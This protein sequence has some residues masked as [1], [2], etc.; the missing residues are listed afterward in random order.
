MEVLPVLNAIGWS[1]EVRFNEAEDWVE[2]RGWEARF[3]I[4][5][6]TGEILA[7]LIDNWWELF[8]EPEDWKAR[9]LQPVVWKKIVGRDIRRTPI[10][11]DRRG[12]ISP[13]AAPSTHT[14]GLSGVGLGPNMRP[15]N[16]TIY[17][18]HETGVVMSRWTKQ[19][20]WTVSFD[21]LIPMTMPDGMDHG[22]FL[23]SVH[24]AGLQL[25]VG[26]ETFGA[27]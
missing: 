4:E 16:T 23:K 11:R 5:Q 25:D 13:V 18:G 22:D 17:L 10:K 12:T 27:W 14:L 6:G 1:D 20:F 2:V 19:T 3:C 21:W 24:L 9:H 7:Q 26:P 15:I 8:C